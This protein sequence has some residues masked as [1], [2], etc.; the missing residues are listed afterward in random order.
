MDRLGHDRSRPL[1]EP[2]SGA[3]AHAG[4]LACAVHSRKAMLSL[5]QTRVRS[6]RKGCS[7][8]LLLQEPRKLLNAIA[9]LGKCLERSRQMMSG[10][11]F[12][13]HALLKATRPPARRRWSLRI[14][15]PRDRL[16]GSSIILSP[17]FAY[18]MQSRAA[19]KLH[20]NG[21]RDVHFPPNSDRNKKRSSDVVM[22]RFLL[23]E[24]LANFV[25]NNDFVALN[26]ICC[27]GD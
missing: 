15:P 17:F 19:G 24:S 8:Q 9:G 21:D 16:R 14:L 23:E 3:V 7:G 27:G 13:L 2:K 18:Q 25:G 26:A 12:L 1:S 11:M 10:E 5:Y 22:C 6:R 20:T 4:M